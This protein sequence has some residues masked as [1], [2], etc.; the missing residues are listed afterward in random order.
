MKMVFDH[1]EQ[2]V[3]CHTLIVNISFK[4]SPLWIPFQQT[5]YT[6]VYSSNDKN[7]VKCQSNVSQ[8]TLIKAFNEQNTLHWNSNVIILTKI[9][10]LV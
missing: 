2:E 4:W 8:R 10:L 7:G 1:C 3:F 9:S 5:R 6:F